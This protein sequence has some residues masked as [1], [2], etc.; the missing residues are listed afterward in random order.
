M[1]ESGRL[2]SLCFND[3]GQ[4]G[5]GDTGSPLHF[6]TRIS[7]LIQDDFWVDQGKVFKFSEERVVFISSSTYSNA[8]VTDKREIW[9]WGWKF[10]LWC[11]QE[12]TINNISSGE[13]LVYPKTNE[14][15]KKHGKRLCR[16]M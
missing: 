15:S 9:V 6:H 2:F 3:T 13:E 5:L 10:A 7:T 4:L 12:E 14:E 8:G 1:T 16:C 11:G